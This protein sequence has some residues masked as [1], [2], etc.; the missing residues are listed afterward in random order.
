VYTFV[1]LETQKGNLGLHPGEHL[2]DRCRYVET[3]GEPMRHTRYSPPFEPLYIVL[4]LIS[5]VI[6]G[7]FCA[8]AGKERSRTTL[9]LFEGEVKKTKDI[10]VLKLDKPLVD[11][12]RGQV[13]STVGRG[14]AEFVGGNVQTWLTEADGN[15]ITKW[16]AAGE[17]A[18]VMNAYYLQPGSH[19]LKF[20]NRV[21]GRTI[22]YIN[23]GGI[24]M[25]LGMTY[26][27]ELTEP[28][29]LAFE[30]VKGDTLLI[31]TVIGYKTCT[32][33]VLKGKKIL[34]SQESRTLRANEK[35]GWGR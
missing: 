20:L 4:I 31:R 28:I 24:S 18:E 6:L 32:I 13:L 14:S 21:N 19:T 11:P 23:S 9:P 16:L 8:A 12:R 2:E 29:S 5:T 34:A 26:Q 10:V 25:E 1:G 30:A 15:P 22:W 35:Q 3:R 7:F 33:Q 27:H 17:N